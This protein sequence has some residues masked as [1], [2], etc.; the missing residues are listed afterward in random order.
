MTNRILILL[1]ALLAVT[2]PVSAA[3]TKH[4]KK[5]AATPAPTPEEAAMPKVGPDGVPI[6]RAASVVVLDGRTGQVLYEKNADEHR[7]AASTQK[8]LTALIVAE[9][10]G[11]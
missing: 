7:P 2:C 10:G 1:L 5:A 8:L 6:T 9:T 4:R 3:T 11:L